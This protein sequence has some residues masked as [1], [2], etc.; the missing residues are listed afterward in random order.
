VDRIRPLLLW[1]REQH[2]TIRAIAILL[3]IP[4]ST[5]RGYLYNRKRKMVPPQNA[6]RIVAVV[7]AHRKTYRPL[8]TWEERPGLRDVSKIRGRAGTSGRSSR[9]PAS[10]GS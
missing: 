10:S 8:D 5:I 2:G 7:L 9:P 6:E 3:D 4:E 1:L